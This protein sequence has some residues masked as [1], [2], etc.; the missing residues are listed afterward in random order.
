MS[1]NYIPGNVECPYGD[2]HAS[3]RVLA[4][5]QNLEELKIQ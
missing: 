3:E 2:G 5:L 1:E 4:V